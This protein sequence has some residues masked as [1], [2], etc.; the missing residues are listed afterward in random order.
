M[1][2]GAYEPQKAALEDMVPDEKDPDLLVMRKLPVENSRIKSLGPPTRKISFSET[3]LTRIQVPGFNL[4][5][6]VGSNETSFIGSRNLLPLSRRHLYA[7]K[8]LNA[9]H[10]EEDITLTARKEETIET[11]R[12]RIW[13]SLHYVGR[14]TSF[15]GIP[16]LIAGRSI[17]RTLYWVVLIFTALAFMGVAMAFITREYFGRKTAF[18]E[19]IQ[20]PDSLEFPAVTICSHNPYIQ[21]NYSQTPTEV[22]V[23]VDYEFFRKDRLIQS[24]A[25]HILEHLERRFNISSI[26]FNSSYTIRTVL[27]EYGNRFTPGYGFFHCRFDGQECSINDFTESVTAFGLCSTFNLNGS[28]WNVSSA[29]PSHGLELILDIIQYDYL[30]FTSHTAGIQ[31]FIHPQDE[32][33]YSGEHRGF[34]VPPGFETQVAI[35]LTNTKLMEPPYGQCGNRPIND[36]YILPCKIATT[37][38]EDDDDDANRS[39]STDH[40]ETVID[41]RCPPPIRRY[42]RKRCLGECEALYQNKICGCKADYLPG[43]NINECDLNMLFGCLLNVTER[44]PLIRKKLCDCPLECNQ[45]RYDTRISQSY[46]PADRYSTQLQRV[47]FGTVYSQSTVRADLM[48]LVVY[49]D[50]LEYREVFQKETYSTF[51]YIGD[52]GGHLGLFTG[53]GLL[54]FFEL[55]ELCF[56]TL[57]PV[58]E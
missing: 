18:S 25:E 30:Y 34:S 1:E 12:F 31:M 46:F 28:A 52:L 6:K 22:Q 55:F 13:R 17:Y 8:Y 50:Q 29:G 26:T 11:L 20:F 40:E 47:L 38:T 56:A 58:D 36:P 4:H 23:V 37:F 14:H 51:Q 48:S 44:F 57:Y 16:H 21:M 2:A 33:P 9:L 24:S 7:S 42:T 32:Y 19:V 39:S 15:H 27:N 43:A 35:S 53:A 10:T 54:T 49:Y 41:S 5:N 3:N 45:K